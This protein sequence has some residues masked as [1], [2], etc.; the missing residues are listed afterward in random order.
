[1]YRRRPKG[2]EMLLVHPG[3]PLWARKDLGSW[4]IPKGEYA[5]A[6]DPLVAAVREFEEEMGM[7]ARGE[8]QPLGELVQ[9]SRKIVKAWAVEGDFDPA[10]LKSNTFELEWPPRSG[11]K[12][13]FPEI[14]RV[15]WFSPEQAREKILPGQREFIA[16]LMQ[17]LGSAAA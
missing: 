4:S 14:D 17:A 9:P 8:F 13:T 5:G 2:L 6:E 12:T 16:R 15:E 3:G 10:K 1:M 11:R 7:P